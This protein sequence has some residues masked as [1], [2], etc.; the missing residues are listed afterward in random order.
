MNGEIIRGV[1]YMPGAVYATHGSAADI[2]LDVEI[3]GGVRF[4]KRTHGGIKVVD[5]GGRHIDICK[6][7]R[8]GDS[9]I[10]PEFMAAY[11]MRIDGA[12]LDHFNEFLVQYTCGAS[13][14]KRY[15]NIFRSERDLFDHEKKM[16]TNECAKMMD[17]SDERLFYL[18]I[19]DEKNTPERTSSIESIGDI[20]IPSTKHLHEFSNAFKEFLVERNKDNGKVK[21]EMA[22]HNSLFELKINPLDG[23]INDVGHVALL[24]KNDSSQKVFVVQGNLTPLGKAFYD[25]CASE[26]PEKFNE[27]EIEYMNYGLLG[28]DG[29]LSNNGANILSILHAKQSIV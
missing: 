13:R 28:E 23:F 8:N 18:A 26:E 25:Y 22:I 4:E 21:G 24:K 16:I 14:T 7:T 29:N 9:Y 12:K 20:T 27:K 10:D 17:F 2:P 19:R 11:C 1:P 3:Y 15:M 6:E 5:G